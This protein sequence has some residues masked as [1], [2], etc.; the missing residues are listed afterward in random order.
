MAGGWVDPLPGLAW[1]AAAEV[2]D[3]PSDLRD[4]HLSGGSERLTPGMC[5]YIYIY[6][7]IIYTY[8]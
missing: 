8:T 5:V 6:T 4:V 3:F 7:H 2:C 1:V